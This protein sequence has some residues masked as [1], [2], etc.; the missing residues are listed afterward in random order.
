MAAIEEILGDPGKYRSGNDPFYHCNGFTT[1]TQ[2]VLPTPGQQWLNVSGGLYFSA[3][4]PN[5]VDGIWLTTKQAFP[6][7][8]TGS[9]CRFSR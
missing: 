2:Q 1:G 5:I 4:D 7:L 9:S 3:V 8:P 6:T